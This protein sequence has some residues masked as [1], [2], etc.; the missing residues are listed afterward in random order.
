MPPKKVARERICDAALELFCRDGYDGASTR[1]IAKRAGVNE[2]T[3]FRLFGTKEKVLLAV[4]DREADIGPHIPAGA[5]E[6][7]DDVASDLA[8]FGGFMLE[9]MLSK[10]PLMKLGMTEMRRRPAIWRHISP[11]PATAIT[12]LSGYFDRAAEKGVIRKVD[13]R[14]AAVVFFSFFFRSMVMTTFLGKDVLMRMD[15]RAIRDFCSMFAEGLR[16]R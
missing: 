9:G 8:R 12:F 11:A 6:P 7:T 10:A 15:E 1:A 2:V 13:S 4:L 16:K 3:I 14:L 5:L